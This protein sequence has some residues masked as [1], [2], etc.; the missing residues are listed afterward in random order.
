MVRKVWI[1]GMFLHHYAMT[2]I[3]RI[4]QHREWAVL[5]VLAAHLLFFAVELLAARLR[6]PG[7]FRSLRR[8]LVGVAV[9]GAYL[10]MWNRW[11]SPEFPHVFGSI[12][13]P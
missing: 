1:G 9:V 7:P 5:A 8:R 6:A 12:G 2:A 13:S 11:I 3:G 10:L 4:M